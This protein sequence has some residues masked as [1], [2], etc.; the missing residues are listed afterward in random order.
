MVLT[1]ELIQKHVRRL[2]EAK[3]TIKRHRRISKKGFIGSVKQHQ[4][5]VHPLVKSYMKLADK[6]DN[7]PNSFDDKTLTYTGKY[8]DDRGRANERL[9]S[10]ARKIQKNPKALRSFKK[11][12]GKNWSSELAANT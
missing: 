12:L 8:D 6:I 1:P 10:L 2:I 5:E 7:I 9:A 3:V 4:R 11:K